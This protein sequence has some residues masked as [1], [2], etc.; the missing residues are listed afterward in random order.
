MEMLLIKYI[1]P[2]ADL[3]SYILFGLTVRHLRL[4]VQCISYSSAYERSSLSHNSE[5]LLAY[6]YKAVIY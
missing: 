2:P 5:N 1:Y 6:N 3:A 4:I